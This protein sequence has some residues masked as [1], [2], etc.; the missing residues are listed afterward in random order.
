LIKNLCDGTDK[1][2]EKFIA[3]F[4]PNGK[5]NEKIVDP[6]AAIKI[7]KAL[8]VPFEMNTSSRLVEPRSVG[9]WLTRSST[10]IKEAFA[11]REEDEKTKSTLDEKKLRTYLGSLIEFVKKNYVFLEENRSR[12]SAE[13]DAPKVRVK[14]HEFQY[15][16]KPRTQKQYAQYDAAMIRGAMVPSFGLPGMF[17]RQIH[18]G[19]SVYAP[20]YISVSKNSLPAVMTGGAQQDVY[21]NMINQTEQRLEAAGF[22]LEQNDLARLKDG[23][24]KIAKYDAKLR[25]LNELLIKVSRVAQYYKDSNPESAESSYIHNISLDQIKN[26]KDA[27]NN[28][29]ANIGQINRC[30]AANMADRTAKCNQLVQDSAKLLELAGGCQPSGVVIR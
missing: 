23:A 25:E 11:K 21:L 6:K 13:Y 10:D 4:N 30:M 12:M 8:G 18:H 9:H 1:A 17:G 22:K 16:K 19:G 29:T 3:N 7:L 24:T 15:A 2:A 27:L 5:L 26:K 14:G 20:E 28:L